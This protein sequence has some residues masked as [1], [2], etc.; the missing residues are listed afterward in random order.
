M[1]FDLS[2]IRTI[3]ATPGQDRTTL[4]L[5]A[6]AVAALAGV[7]F[8]AANREP[9][10]I[11]TAQPPVAV[12]EA[13]ATPP[14]LP[15]V[16]VVPPPAATPPAEPAPDQSIASVNQTPTGNQSVA[17]GKPGMEIAPPAK[18]P[19]T[20]SADAKPKPDKKATK[21]A[22]APPTETP[23][24][25]PSAQGGMPSLNTQ[26]QGYVTFARDVDS[27]S[28]MALQNPTE[29]RD[30]LNRLK[31]HQPKQ[32]T[33]GWIAYGAS[34]AADN[35]DFSASLKKEVEKR[36]RDTVEQKI[37]S[38]PSYLLRLDGAGAALNDIFAS[39][40][41]DTAKLNTLQQ[42][43][44]STAYEFQK[45]KKWGAL[46]R[47]TPNAFASLTSPLPEPERAR[48]FVVAAGLFGG[49][50]SKAP[51]VVPTGPTQRALEL[52]ARLTI[53]EG[54][55][56]TSSVPLVVGDKGLEQCLRWAKLNL[57]QCM[58]ASHFPSEEAYCTGKHALAEVSACWS[59]LL[60][61]KS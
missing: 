54:A 2:K 4:L 32:M 53:G 59:Q 33:E 43:F 19:E 14:P 51:E 46:E 27:I 35:K 9:A 57:N 13:P 8:V 45:I 16:A 23:A 56:D 17:A 25:P 12:A 21:M 40:A 10:P 15:E 1:S 49:G 36:G 34:L 39:V 61:T 60:P 52:A 58:A 37:A 20:K 31:K 5:G 38:D 50:K 30:A 22:K 41:S 26:A 42:R 7:V 6:A 47:T 11:A 28:K 24:P 48:D 44:I 18:V 3:L 29:V 55:N